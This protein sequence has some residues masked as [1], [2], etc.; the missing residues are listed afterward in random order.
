VDTCLVIDPEKLN[1]EER[2]HLL[3]EQMRH[4]QR[5]IIR[6]RKHQ[7]EPTPPTV[8]AENLNGDGIPL[9][10][11]CYGVTEKSAFLTYLTVE[12]DG[13][14]VGSKVFQ[15]LSAA[16]EAVSLVR[17][18]GWTFWKLLDGRTLKEAFRD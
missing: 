9:G 4:M 17:R 18:S 3:E 15:S 7:Q 11:I 5:V 14:V 1:P 6:L 10:T 8:V 2:I 13:Y 16:A 12:E